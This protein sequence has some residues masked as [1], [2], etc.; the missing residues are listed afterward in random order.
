MR[1]HKANPPSTD[2]I[3]VGL[4]VYPSITTSIS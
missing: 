1:P 3:G 4:Y 2:A